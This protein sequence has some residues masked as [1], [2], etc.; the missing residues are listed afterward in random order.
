[1]VV[2]SLSVGAPIIRSVL[3][4]DHIC[5]VSNAHV[6][7]FAHSSTVTA[8]QAIYD[9]ANNPTGV[10]ALGR[11]VAV[12][13]A[14]SEG[15]LQIIHFSEEKDDQGIRKVSKHKILPAHSS[16]IKAVCLT[17]D[18]RLICS[19]SATVRI[20]VLSSSSSRSFF[21]GHVDTFAHH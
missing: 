14:R 13:P 11:N 5:I 1:M 4:P 20:Q 7:L 15:Q 9:T 3:T 6:N 12:F 8:R 21:P 16:A 18:E 2:G 10:C 17:R 19:A